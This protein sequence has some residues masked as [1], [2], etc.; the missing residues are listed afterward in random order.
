MNKANCVG[1]DAE[2]TSEAT[3]CFEHFHQFILDVECDLSRQNICVLFDDSYSYSH[4]CL[5]LNLLVTY[6]ERASV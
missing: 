3:S 5:N 2:E 4:W 1:L 6:L